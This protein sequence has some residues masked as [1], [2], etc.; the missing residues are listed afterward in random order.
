M[1]DPE[2]IGQV[3]DN[4]LANA[5]K[6]SPEG[7]EILVSLRGEGASVRLSVSDAGIGI[8]APR[9]PRLFERFYLVPDSSENASGL[10]LGLAISRALVVEHGGRIEVKS[11][12]GRGSTFTIVLPFSG[13]FSIRQET[14]A[15]TSRELEVARLVAAALSNREIG[16]RLYISVGTVANH[17]QDIFAKLGVSGRGQ[18][19]LWIAEHGLLTESSPDLGR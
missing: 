14:S 2:R 5:V 10:G 17:I 9:L 12:L 11:T 15:L 18:I 13:D 1:W 19:T 4:L 8:S 6:Y 3:L 16:E 7:G